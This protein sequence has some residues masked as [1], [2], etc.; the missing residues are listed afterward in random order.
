MEHFKTEAF[1]S[2]VVFRD[3][4]EVDV[5]TIVRYWHD[6]DPAFL[7][8]LG[9]D[10]SKLEPREATR[11]RLLKSVR[12]KSVPAK[13]YFVFESEAELLAYTNLNFRTESDACAHFHLL[14]RTPRIKAIMY[15]LF[16]RVIY[17]FFTRFPLQRIE[18]QTLPENRNI[19]RLLKRF[20]LTPTRKFMDNPDGFGRAGE[21]NI[22]ELT[23]SN[24]RRLT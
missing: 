20:H 19:D 24:L 10:L 14:K 22:W 17:T 5:E 7:R 2:K 15:V 18:M 9:A 1:G 8:S 12:R 13:A 11:E 3:L 21:L 16:P 23:R 6:T 4:I